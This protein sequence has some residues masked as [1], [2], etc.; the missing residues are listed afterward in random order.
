MNFDEV[1]EVATL[2][3]AT[4]DFLRQGPAKSERMRQRLALVY[5][6]DPSG[7]SW[8]RFVNNHAWAFVKLQ[9][10]GAIRKLAPGHYELR[11]ERA[12]HQSDAATWRPYRPSGWYRSHEIGNNGTR[13]PPMPSR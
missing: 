1:P 12:A 3:K 13:K 2:A 6:I 11:S 4:A 8:P 7:A 9:A 10:Q 5:G